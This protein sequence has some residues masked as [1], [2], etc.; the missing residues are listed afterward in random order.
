ML[1]PHQGQLNP[2]LEALQRIQQDVCLI[3]DQTTALSSQRWQTFMQGA[4]VG[5]SA[6]AAAC[7]L[8]WRTY[9]IRQ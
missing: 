9:R 1:L 3:R 6:T 8:I 4:M 5:A 2:T 7:C